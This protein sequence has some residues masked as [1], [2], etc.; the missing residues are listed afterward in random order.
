MYGKLKIL[1][2]ILPNKLMKSI[3]PIFFR[4]DFFKQWFHFPSVTLISYLESCIGNGQED[5]VI[6]CL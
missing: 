5:I 3:K 6:F 2:L 4:L 1:K